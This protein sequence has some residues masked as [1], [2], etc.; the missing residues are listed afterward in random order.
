MGDGE[1]PIGY[2]K[3]QSIKI[4]EKR[5]GKISI[6]TEKIITRRE[7]GRERKSILEKKK[8]RQHIYKS[9]KGHT[10]QHQK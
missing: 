2:K 10:K 7:K 6:R 4:V 1:F 8:K 3:L 9:K 5:E